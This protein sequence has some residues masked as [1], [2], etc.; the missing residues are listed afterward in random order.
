MGTFVELPD[1]QAIQARWK[2]FVGFGVVLAVLGAIALLNAVDATLITTI[3]V[4][5]LLLLA[6]IMQLIAAFA[7]SGGLG[8]RVL[9]AVLGVLYLL[10]GFNLIADPMAGAIALT[11]VIA[12]V[13]IAEGIIRLWTAISERPRQALLIAAIG[14]INI[15]LGIWLWTG[16]PY[17]GVAIGL[18]VG[19]QLL[20]AGIIWIA[21]GWMARSLTDTTRTL[22][23]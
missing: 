1:A 5:I 21:A 7:T 3:Y 20:M 10:V 14:V 15:L 12:I 4:G 22:P 6:G 17:S 23:A 11:I 16:L 18:F 9:Q 13:L 8:G 2:W 19:L